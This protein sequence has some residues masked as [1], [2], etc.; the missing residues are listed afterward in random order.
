VETVLHSGDCDELSPNFK[1]RSC[2]VKQSVFLC[3]PTLHGLSKQGHHQQFWTSVHA[4]HAVTA[5]KW[6]GVDLISVLCCC[7][8]SDDVTGGKLPLEVGGQGNP[9]YHRNV[10][11]LS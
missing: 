10:P 7:Q 11:D 1:D 2:S 8:Q 3:C 9:L 4:V 6:C 5:K